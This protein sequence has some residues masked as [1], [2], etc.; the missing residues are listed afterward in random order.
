DT[1]RAC[2]NGSCGPKLNGQT[3]AAAGECLSNFCVDGVCCES[4]CAGACRSCALASS[5]GMCKNTPGGNSDP[6][7]MCTDTGVA[8]CGTNGKCDGS[9]ACQKYAD[10]SV[11][12]QET[13]N[14]NVSTGASTCMSGRCT[15]PASVPCSP[16]VCNGTGAGG[17]C[18]TV[19]S[20]NA[21]C[22]THNVCNGNSGGKRLNGAS[23]SV[24]TE[25]MTG[26]CAQGVCCN[27]A[28]NTSCK[29]CA[30]SSTTGACTNVTANSADPAGL[31]VTQAQTT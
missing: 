8:S 17:K 11:C 3:C 1:G 15:A 25:C 22:L 23:G 18:F 19:C 6:R 27:S 31:C 20:G 30:L 13:C 14:S 10:G 21:Q 12:A 9:G 7:G 4:A 29:S 2:V 24:G 28:C 16:Y 26:F 5:P